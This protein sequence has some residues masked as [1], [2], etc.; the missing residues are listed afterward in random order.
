MRTP[1]SAT[2]KD[3]SGRQDVDLRDLTRSMIRFFLS[4]WVPKC[5]MSIERK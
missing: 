2:N 4:S 3:A 5:E 1:N